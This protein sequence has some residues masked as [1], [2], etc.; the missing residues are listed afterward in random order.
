[1][2]A[3]NAGDLWKHFILCE[4]AE[5]LISKEM[6]VLYVESHVGLPFYSLEQHGEWVGGIGRFRDRL[7]ELLEFSYFGI[8][9]RMNA[10]ALS[11]YPGSACLVLQMAD[12]SGTDLQADLWDVD[13]QVACAWD[14]I[15][16][17][18]SDKF[19]FHRGDGFSGAASILAASTPALLLIDPPYTDGMDAAKALELA[20]SAGNM[21]WTVLIW[22]MMDGRAMQDYDDGF[23]ILSLE[24]AK[25]GMSC[26]KWSGAQMALIGDE[27]LQD[28]VE[29]RAKSFIEIIQ[30]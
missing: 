20:D 26:G 16:I 3:G 5:W 19:R 27:D 8:I 11:N 13:P 30:S 4:T 22:Q 7:E 2:H 24:F 23:R 12:R 9:S 21:G 29:W 17:G 28:Y 10:N 1:M 15:A 14:D 25:A 18:R 6:R